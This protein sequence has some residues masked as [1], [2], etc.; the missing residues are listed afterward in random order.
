MRPLRLHLLSEACIK[1]INIYMARIYPAEEASVLIDKD[2]ARVN[3]HGRGASTPPRQ[4]GHSQSLLD[5]VPHHQGSSGV[6]CQGGLRTETQEV[7]NLEV[8]FRMG[9]FF[10]TNLQVDRWVEGRAGLPQPQ[11]LIILPPHLLGA[12]ACVAGLQPAVVIAVGKQVEA[13]EVVGPHGS[14][15]R[16][17]A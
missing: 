11:E 8:K 16:Q 14:A 13:P 15:H 9:L 5:P 4:G 3:K 2:G 7:G 12:P 10:K 6:I 1:Q 17:H